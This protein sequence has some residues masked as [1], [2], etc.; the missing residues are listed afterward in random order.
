MLQIASALPAGFPAP[1]L[2]TQHIGNLASVLPELMRAR[3]PNRAQHPVD[4]DPPVP[5]TIY[6]APPDRHMLLQDGR[7]RL[8]RGPKENYC[9]P[10]ID[11]MFRSVALSMRARAVGVVLTGQLDDGTAG[12]KAIKLCGGTAI[13]QDPATAL[14][15]AMPASALANV[16]VDLRVRLEH[17]VPALERIVGASARPAPEPPDTLH[18]E[19][20]AHEGVDPMGNLA[21]IAEPSTLSC[22]DC[23]GSLWELKDRKPLRYRCHTGHAFTAAS[24]GFAQGESAEH[25]LWGGVRALQEREYLLRR[26]ARVARAQGDHAQADAGERQADN[27]RARADELVRM[28]EHTEEGG[29]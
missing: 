1:V 13:V 6:V 17:I 28:I 15:P 3:G 29:A 16:E 10:A 8:S 19:Q 24:L 5:G 23:G 25:S 7:L 18:H 11:P 4:G 26:L 14:E 12:L 9:R 21:A 27:A 22:P 20:L 2:V